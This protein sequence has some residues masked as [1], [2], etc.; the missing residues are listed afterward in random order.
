MLKNQEVVVMRCEL[1]K[2]ERLYNSILCLT[3]LMRKENELIEKGLVEE[4]ALLADEKEFLVNAII[5][6]KE[7]MLGILNKKYSVDLGIPK[8]QQEL[9]KESALRLF[10]ISEENARLIARRLHVINIIIGSMQRVS[11]A[12]NNI[13]SLYGSSGRNVNSSHKIGHSH[14]NFNSTI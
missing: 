9:I 4:S 2:H 10:E 6:N 1:S 11:R 5:G 3:D 8:K 14:F 7:L 13:V 12:E